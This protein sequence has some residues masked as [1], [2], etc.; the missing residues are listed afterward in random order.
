MNISTICT[1]I[2]NWMTHELYVWFANCLCLLPLASPEVCM[3]ISHELCVSVN[4]STICTSVTNFIYIYTNYIC[5][6]QTARACYRWRRLRCICIWVAIYVYL[7][8]MS[9]DLC[10]SNRLVYGWIWVT[11]YVNMY[12]YMHE[13]VADCVLQMLQRVEVCCIVWHCVVRMCEAPRYRLWPKH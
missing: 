12:L 2:K 11:N 8:H 5:D 6:S 13:A 3:C 9:H 10:V 4:I 1:W 7:I